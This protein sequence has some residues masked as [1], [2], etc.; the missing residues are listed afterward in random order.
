MRSATGEVAAAQP[1][2]PATV[3][4]AATAG[5]MTAAVDPAAAIAVDLAATTGEI[6]AVNPSQQ[7]Q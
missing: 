3:N 7:Q 5:E 6:A 2:V 4:P 1:A